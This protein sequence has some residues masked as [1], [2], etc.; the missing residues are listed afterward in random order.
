M[1]FLM[2]SCKKASALIDKK[3][4]FGISWKEKVQLKMH[5]AMCDACGVYEKQSK[6]IDNFL[7]KTIS[8]SGSENHQ[9]IE[10]KE[11]QKK[12]ISKL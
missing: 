8:S 10:N 11:L 5:T 2:L 7:N 4:L 1:R 9:V 3:Q 12:I 6:I